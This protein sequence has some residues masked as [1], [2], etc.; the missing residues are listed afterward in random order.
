MT[1]NTFKLGFASR[2][3][4]RTTVHLQLVLTLLL[5]IL[6]SYSLWSAKPTSGGS[7]EAPTLNGAAAIEYLKGQGLFPALA[8]A[9]REAR[10]GEAA[11]D[12]PSCGYVERQWFSASDG[13]SFD[14]FGQAVAIDGDTIVVGV[15]DDTLGPVKFQGTAYVFVRNGEQWNERARLFPSDGGEDDSFG[16][17][18]AIS[19]DYI[20]VGAPRNNI[21]AV[22]DQGA[23]YVYFNNGGSWLEQQRLLANDGASA[24][25]FGSAVAISGEHVAVGAMTADIS[26]RQNQGAVYRFRRSGSVW[27]QAVKLTAEDGAVGDML[28]ATVALS[29][30]VLLAGAP[31]DDIGS[32]GDQG[33]A[34]IFGDSKLAFRLT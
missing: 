28:G 11:N 1:A 5:I 14:R 33:S 6:L 8:A 22:T 16:F 15:P 24:D 12:D 32:N 31:G 20:V 13:S 4:R 30:F 27:T 23:A 21:G 9:V 34:Y 29:G 18:V 25:R 19:G 7:L 10:L 3:L 2:R 17:S 26:G